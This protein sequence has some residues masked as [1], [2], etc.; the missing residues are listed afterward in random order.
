MD[1]QKSQD[2]VVLSIPEV[3]C[4]DKRGKLFAKS[5]YLHMSFSICKFWGRIECILY[6]KVRC[7]IA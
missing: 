4:M 3:I 6:P 1:K 7:W 2:F 5:T